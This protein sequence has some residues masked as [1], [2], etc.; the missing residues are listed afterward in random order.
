M[1]IYPIS[2]LDEHGGLRF[3]S[4]VFKDFYYS[5]ENPEAFNRTFIDSIKSGFEAFSPEI[6]M[7]HHLT[8]NEILL[9]EF[10]LYHVKIVN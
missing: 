9:I 1:N 7:L 6:I 4:S 2:T 5:D 10:L 8:T 3:V